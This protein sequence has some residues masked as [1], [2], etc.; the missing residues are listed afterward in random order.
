MIKVCHMTSVHH[1]EDVR[2]FYKE[3]VSLAKAGYETYLVQRGESYDKNGVHVVGVGEPPAGRLKRMTSF[4][5]K[6]Y[7]A[8]LTLDADIYQFHDPELLPWGL[9][10]KKRGKKVIFDSHENY[11]LQMRGKPYLSGWASSILAAVYQKYEYAVV[12]KLDAIIYPCTFQGKLPYKGVCHRV[13]VLDNV[14][15]LEEV[16]DQYQGREHPLSGPMCYF[17]SLS[18]ARCVTEIIESAV[19]T[20]MPLLLAGNFSSDTY[21]REC[22]TLMEGHEHIQWL[23]RLSR[24]E[25]IPLLKKA[26]V[27]LCPEK[28]ILQYN[29]VDNLA[30]KSYEYMAMGLP[31]IVADYPFIRKVMAEY[32][33]GIPVDPDS[34]ES[35]SQAIRYLLDHP[36]EASQMGENGRKAIKERFNWELEQEKLFALYEDILNEK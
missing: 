27:G 26:S 17:G 33:Y 15:S 1:P 7:Q 34:T 11:S 25:I 16:Y 24:L 9:K 12:R 35:I 4:S 19:N 29:T 5:K 23:G 30:T 10:L 20:G 36:E 8:A 32:R 28:N 2:I 22:L 13:A 3:C 31:V 14:P 21:Q 6:V 18:P